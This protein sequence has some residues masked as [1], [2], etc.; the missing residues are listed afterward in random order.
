M[1]SCASTSATP[2][3]TEAMYKVRFHLGRGEHFMHWQIK[4]KL[5]TGDGTGAKEVV[6][7][8]D[9]QHKSIAMFGCRLRVQPS[10]A[11]KIHDGANKSVCA[12]IECEHTQVVDKPIVMTIF[13]TRISFNPKRSVHWMTEEGEIKDGEFMPLI[14]TNERELF[15]IPTYE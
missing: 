6:S 11:Q 13:D 9:P 8:V 7:Y 10:T 5:N 1:T 3:K 4:S 15:I 14:V 2:L 12:W